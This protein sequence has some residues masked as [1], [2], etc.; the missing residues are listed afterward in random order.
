MP[1]LL[2]ALFLVF[3]TPP[4]EPK[5]ATVEGAVVHAASKA[6][7]RKAKVTLTSIG[8]ENTTSMETGDDGRFTLK[9]VKP[10]RYRVSAEKTGYQTTA[11]GARRPA[12]AV[13]QVLRI[14]AGAALTGIDIALPRQGAIAGKILDADNEPV[15]GALVLALANIYY[16][17]GRRTRIPRGSVPV[18]SSD[19]G[20]YRIGSLPP[21]KY[22]I[23]AIPS[24]FVQPA[25]LAKEAKP[26]TEDALVTTCYPNVHQM[27][28]ATQF[29]IK[30]STEIPGI[31]MRLIKTRTVTV[32]GRI[33]GVPAG[34]G[35][36]T[37]LNLNTKTAGPMGNAIH[38]RALVQG[39]DGK[40]E[41][42][43]VA[44]GSYIL[45]TLPTGLGNSA[46]IVKANVEVGDQPITDLQVPAITP[47][48]IK[49]KVIAE[50]G[51]EMKLGSVRVILSPAD[52]ITSTVSMG[53][54]NADG[55]L[56]LGNLVPGRH[57][58]QLTGVP[59]THYVREIRAGDLLAEG[60]EVDIPA[61]ATQLTI[62]LALG[63]AEVNG[64][65]RNDKGEPFA[66]A[67][68]GLIPE[69]RRPF[70]IKATRTDQSGAF[71]FMGVAPGEYWLVALE[72]VEPG[73]LQDDEF[74]KPMRTKLK[75]V[76]VEDG[77][78]QGAELTV[79]P[80]APDR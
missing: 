49:G 55:D 11:Y 56:A 54:P 60:D 80:A 21:G 69:P 63:R 71:K 75:K 57:R 79:L 45:H 13:G 65:A 59:Y 36:I 35:S 33:S 51:P 23:C 38:P 22:I 61:S 76:Q 48:E 42:K 27:A 18:M 39:V 12:D 53:N 7:V 72:T 64:L 5:L 25:P 66:G 68:V 28:D 73:S 31:D 26:G 19:L 34:A 41:F 40:F 30:D 4:A 24:S 74:L 70:R 43:N 78:S 67:H 10:G 3:Q 15:R 2:I 58:V 20:E 6:A 8:A 46:F 44:P 32:Q 17:N 50:P 9:E 52:D 77:G 1:A 62:V 47:F 29:E 37:I 14:D 16:L